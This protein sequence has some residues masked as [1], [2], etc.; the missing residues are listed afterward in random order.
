MSNVKTLELVDTFSLERER[1]IVAKRLPV[2]SSFLGSESFAC[3]RC[4]ELIAKNVDA[5]VLFQNLE[6]AERLIVTCVC[7]GN[8]LLVEERRSKPC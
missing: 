6:G 1:V 7:Q 4:G 5:A 3:G 8:N 2:F